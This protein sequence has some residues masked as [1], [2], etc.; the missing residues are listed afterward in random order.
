A[1][2]HGG[3]SPGRSNPLPS[4]Y[5]G[6]AQLGLGTEARLARGGAGF[7]GVVPGGRGMIRVGFV[8][9]SADQGWLGGINYFRNLFRAIERSKFCSLQ[10][11]VFIGGGGGEKAVWGSAAAAVVR[12]VLGRSQKNPWLLWRVSLCGARRGLRLSRHLA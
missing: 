2:V 1:G 8:P 9:P 12:H 3:R 6:R 7:C 5:I 4:R 11:V 10:P